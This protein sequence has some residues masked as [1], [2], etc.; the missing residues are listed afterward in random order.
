[1]K[2]TFKI[3]GFTAVTLLDWPGKIAA[4]V[5][6]PRCNFRCPF[7]YNIELVLDSKELSE[8]PE[9]QIIEHL[10]SK[11]KW[12]DGVVISGGETTLWPGLVDFCRKIKKLGF[13]IQLQT[14]GSNPQ[15]LK[16]LIAQKL[17]DCI[18]MDIKGP[19]KRYQ[20][21]TRSKINP[22]LIKK[23]AKIIKANPQI[24][25]EFRTTVVPGLINE[26]DIEQIGKD[27]SGDKIPYFLQQFLNQKTLD[28]SFEKV[29]SYLKGKLE[30]MKKIAEKYF[31]K[32]EIRGVR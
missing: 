3:K 9:K 26:S 25:A 30:K 15:V 20:E 13:K 1:M 32:V 11:K 28:P 21:I 27:F 22:D 14:N 6:T 24:E 23:S 17:I 31:K 19:L 18:A 7:C 10:T 16:K 8:I 29:E 2:D 5:F 4:M 12:L